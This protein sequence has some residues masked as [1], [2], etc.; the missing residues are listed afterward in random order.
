MAGCFAHFIFFK[1]V[2]ASAF[3]REH[4]NPGRPDCLDILVLCNIKVKFRYG[5]SIAGK[6]TYR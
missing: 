6:K 2:N 3:N 4:L 1:K 5:E